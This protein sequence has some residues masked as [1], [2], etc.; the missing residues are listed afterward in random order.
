M[1]TIRGVLSGVV[2]ALVASGC[3]PDSASLTSDAPLNVATCDT[4]VRVASL[5]RDYDDGFGSNT[6]LILH[7]SPNHEFD[8]KVEDVVRDVATVGG[9]LA[10][11]RIASS[12]ASN[13]EPMGSWDLAGTA[14]NPA[15]L[16]R[17]VEPLA[18]ASTCEILDRVDQPTD[19][20]KGADLL[21]ALTHV[22]RQKDLSKPE[23]ENK[24]ILI[25]QGGIHRTI[26]VDLGNS[27]TEPEDWLSALEAA[28]AQGRDVAASTTIEIFGIALTDEPISRTVRQN[29]IAFWGETCEALEAEGVPC[30]DH[31]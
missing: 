6:Y 15:A 9:N 16:K 25:T 23:S 18:V 12:N 30:S 14:K 11:W 17:E 5:D 29:T 28:A 27:D 31:S 3:I 21:G 22:L 1:K 8:E 10:A 19:G 2:L 26:D 24:I 7:L 13:I 20:D 4:D